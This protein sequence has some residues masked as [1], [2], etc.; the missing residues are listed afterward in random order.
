MN[1]KVIDIESCK[2]ESIKEFSL[3]TLGNNKRNSVNDF[4]KY[5]K[6]SFFI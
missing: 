3:K 2:Y 1:L 6:V 5:L 4:A